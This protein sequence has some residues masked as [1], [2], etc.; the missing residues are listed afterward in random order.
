MTLASSTSDDVQ[1]RAPGVPHHKKNKSYCAPVG[2]PEECRSTGLREFL[3]CVTFAGIDKNRTVA[4]GRVSHYY[5][6]AYVR[7]GFGKSSLADLVAF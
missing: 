4:F 6:Q 7:F 2:F 3:Y 1:S 5:L